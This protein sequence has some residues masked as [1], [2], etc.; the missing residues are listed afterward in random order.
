MITIVFYVPGNCKTTVRS[1]HAAGNTIYTT[2][3]A[4]SMNAGWCVRSVAHVFCTSSLIVYSS[5]STPSPMTDSLHSLVPTEYTVPVASSDRRC[6][7]SIPNHC[8]LTLIIVPRTVRG[9]QHPDI[10]NTGL[11]LLRIKSIC[12]FLLVQS[13]ISTGTQRAVSTGLLVLESN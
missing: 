3:V 8:V 5:I 6:R 13:V 12:H 9:I 7:V 10:G 11:C 1:S 2:R 4:S